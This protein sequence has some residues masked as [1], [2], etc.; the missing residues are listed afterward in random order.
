VTDPIVRGL[1]FQRLA[2]LVADR[3]RDRILRGDL[4]D[5]DVLP[6]ED[7]L[8]HEYPVSKVS[9]REALRILE[10]E[11][12]LTVR[13][14]NVGGAIVHRP[15]ERSVSYMLSL[16]LAA[17]RVNLPDLAEALAETEAT[18]AGLCAERKDRMQAVVP[19][20]QDTHARRVSATDDLDVAF[21][22]SQFHLQIIELCGTRTLSLMGS[23]LYRLWASQD[24]GWQPRRGNVEL[25]TTPT[26]RHRDNVVAVHQEIIDLI[27]D[28]AAGQVAD[29]MRKHRL[30][31]TNYPKSPHA[32]G[33]VDPMRL[34]RFEL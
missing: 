18:C 34:R 11:G 1:K 29:L 12:L 30:A 4:E 17:D 7:D 14:G 26:P 2:E 24:T 8:R 27:A 13:R 16:V 31:V 28:G 6:K 23:A 19:Q 15:A 33:A 21:Q 20:L 25:V 10:A 3:L 5:G 22:S 32:R 9:L